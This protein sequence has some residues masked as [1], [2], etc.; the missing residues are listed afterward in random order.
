M[1]GRQ[2]RNSPKLHGQIFDHFF[3]EY[4]Y[5]D[6]CKLYSQCRQGQAGTHQVVSEHAVGTKGAADLGLR[7]A[8]HFRI[9]GQNPWESRLKKG[10]D[11]HQLEHYPLIEAIRENKPYNEVEPAAMSTMTAILGR[12]AVYSGK[13]VEWDDAFNSKLQLM[14]SKVSWDME[15]PVKPDADGNYPVAVPGKTVAL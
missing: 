6:G 13:Q 5:E 15:P 14:P 11:G 1:G 10:E 7:N 2:V 8:T 12:M 9:T 3:V 4:E